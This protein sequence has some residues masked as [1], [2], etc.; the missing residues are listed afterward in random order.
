MLQWSFQ[1]QPS[2]VLYN[3]TF[4]RE[5]LQKTTSEFLQKDIDKC[6]EC[7]PNEST[8]KIHLRRKKGKQGTEGNE[9]KRHLL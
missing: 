3:N 8:R 9:L 4:S 1:K 6:K 2:E 5:H 7:H